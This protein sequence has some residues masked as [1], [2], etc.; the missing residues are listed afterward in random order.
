MMEEHFKIGHKV[1]KVHINT[2][3]SCG[4]DGQQFTLSVEADSSA[5][6]LDLVMGPRRRRAAP[7]RGNDTPTFTRI[8]CHLTE[9]LYALEYPSRGHARGAEA[10]F[11]RLPHPSNAPM[12]AVTGPDRG[13]PKRQRGNARRLL[14][15]PRY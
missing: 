2:S 11:V 10:V 12:D 13:C 6:F 5:D 1:P 7:L 8:T 14:R 9:C 4:P 3:L 15:G